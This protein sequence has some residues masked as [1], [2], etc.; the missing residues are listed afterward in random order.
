V[1]KAIQGPGTARAEAWADTH[2]DDFGAGR[3]DAVLAALRQ[4]A[5]ES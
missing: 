4:P 5:D 2:H 1:A 3:I